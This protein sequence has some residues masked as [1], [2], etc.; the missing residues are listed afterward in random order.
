MIAEDET[1]YN[2]VGEY[3]EIIPPRK[4]VFTWNSEMVKDTLLTIELE[5]VNG[6]TE[7]TLTHDLFLSAEEK[8]RHHQGWEGCLQNL[9]HYFNP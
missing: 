7:L 5:E 9:G 2:H 3:K 1:T 8:E 4:I 6:Y